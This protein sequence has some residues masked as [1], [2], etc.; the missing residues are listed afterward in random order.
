[1]NYTPAIYPLR[2]DSSS[3]VLLALA[4][5]SFSNSSFDMSQTACLHSLIF[6]LFVC[7]RAVSPSMMLSLPAF[8]LGWEIHLEFSRILQLIRAP[9]GARAYP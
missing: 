3:V 6:L 4:V 8:S 5:S 9:L 2:S 7:P 1:M